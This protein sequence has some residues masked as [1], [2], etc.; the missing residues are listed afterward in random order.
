MSFE[1]DKKKKWISEERVPFWNKELKKAFG[2]KIN[3]VVQVEKL[4]EDPQK[5]N[6]FDTSGLSA[7]RNHLKSAAADKDF[8]DYVAQKV[9]KIVV[10]YDESLSSPKYD[11]DAQTTTFTITATP[12]DKF[13]VGNPIDYLKKM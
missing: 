10:S 3:L 7:L 5:I 12:K 4:P 8:K 6:L 13:F 1:S 2:D 11:Y 9:S